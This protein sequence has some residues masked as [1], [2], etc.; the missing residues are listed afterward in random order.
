MSET[1]YVAQ[2]FG[3]WVVLD[4]NL[5]IT[6]TSGPEWGLNMYGVLEGTIAPEAA[7]RWTPDGHPLV[8]AWGTVI[9]F[10]TGDETAKRRWQGIVDR[11]IPDGKNLKIRARELHGYLDGLTYTGRVHG[12]QVDPAKVFAQLYEEIQAIPGGDHGITVTG[13]TTLRVGTD[14]DLKAEAALN[15]R[16]TR[17]KELEAKSKPRK[18][19]ETKIKEIRAM[20]ADSIKFW[21]ENR[22]IWA[23]AYTVLT[24]RPGTPAEIEQ[25]KANAA[26]ARVNLKF[27]QDSR[28]TMLDPYQNQLEI[29][30]QAEEPFKTAYDAAVK[31]YNTA[32]EK[33]R[34]DGGGLKIE[35]ADYPDL[36]KELLQ[37]A[38][39][40]GFEFYT[41]ATWTDDTAPDFRVMIAYPST[42]RARSDLTFQQ[43]VNIVSE[44]K[45]REI[46]YASEI[47][48]RGAGEGD[49]AIRENA[50][51]TDWRARRNKVL[52]RTETK[53][54]AALRAE[55]RKVLGWSV[56]DLE[57][58]AIE[59]R[60]HDLARFY[61]WAV[62]DSILV[63]GEIPHIGEYAEWHRIISWRLLPNGNAQLDLERVVST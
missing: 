26:A 20:F 53:R 42:G 51:R 15:I 52:S 23:K 25:A 38:D 55:V 29:A 35:G 44:L 7:N 36:W 22:D 63:Q 48:G 21:T 54:R 41:R 10:E 28:N 13:S 57:I 39:T 3:T 34:L 1:H 17:K 2:R 50:A 19:I 32:K 45:P 12:V 18:A 11:V 14:S 43:G 5:P 16:D 8:A 47:L 33:A 37:L 49:E 9:S 24:K 6:V 59:V 31:V 60:Q 61:S 27:F 58:P 62:G 46:D 30:K 56:G 40:Y 4:R